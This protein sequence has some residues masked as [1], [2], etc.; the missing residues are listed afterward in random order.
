MNN[1]VV[2]QQNSDDLSNGDNLAAIASWWSNLADQEVGWQQ[3]LFSGSKDLAA[4][5]WQPHKFDEQLKIVAP[6]IRGITLFWRHESSNEERNITPQKLQLNL[7]QQELF[8]FPQSQPV[9]VKIDLPGIVYQKLSLVNPEIA[10]TAKA[11][12]KVILLRDEIQK[13]EIKITLDSD[14]LELLRD[15]LKAE[16]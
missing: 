12:G 1:V 4:L 2:W 5:D 15:R 9:V 8:I 7:T 14:K 13:L 16:N 6:Q 3:R 11:D 10:A